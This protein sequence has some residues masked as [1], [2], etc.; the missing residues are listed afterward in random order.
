MDVSLAVVVLAAAILFLAVRYRRRAGFGGGRTISHDN[1]TLRAQRHGLIGRPDRI[2]RRGKT[3]IVEDKKPSTRAS[4][5]HSLSPIESVRHLRIA[6]GS[7]IDI[8]D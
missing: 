4:G 5:R 6:D 7:P 2:V 8:A 1:I 3:I